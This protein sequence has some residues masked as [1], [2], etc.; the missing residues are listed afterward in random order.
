MG[1]TFT[2]YSLHCAEHRNTEHRLILLTRLAKFE[3]LILAD[4]VSLGGKLV[5]HLRSDSAPDSVVR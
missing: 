1:I 5:I 3:N 2:L 4:F